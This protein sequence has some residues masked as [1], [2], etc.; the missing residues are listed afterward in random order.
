MGSELEEGDLSL[1]HIRLN[2]TNNQI[3][4]QD[5]IPIKERIRD[6]HYFEEINKFFLFIENSAAI[7]ILEKKDI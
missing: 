5:I 1:H 2:D 3:I 4:Y 6:I 7:A